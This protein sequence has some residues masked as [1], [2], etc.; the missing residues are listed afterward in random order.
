M[1]S[2]L[3]FLL[4]RLVSTTASQS[5][6]TFSPTL[7]EAIT[8]LMRRVPDTANSDP[9]PITNDRNAQ[10]VFDNVPEGLSEISPGRQPG[11]LVGKSAPRKGC[12]IFHELRETLLAGST[13][14]YSSTVDHFPVPIATSGR[15][16]APTQIHA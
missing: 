12:R 14:D 2:D 15:Q 11:D 8:C 1:A 3:I 10:G 9:E 16:Y 6:P 13:G 7:H 4:A 5:V